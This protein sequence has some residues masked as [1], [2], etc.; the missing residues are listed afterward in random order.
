[1]SHGS[2]GTWNGLVVRFL[3]AS[4]LPGIALAQQTVR[5]TVRFVD[6]LGYSDIKEVMLAMG[7]AHCQVE[8]YPV[9]GQLDLLDGPG[10][11][12][13]AIAQFGSATNLANEKCSL[14]VAGSSISG[15][16]N[17]LSVA[18]AVTFP[19]IR[20]ARWPFAATA[21]AAD[22]TALTPI[23][24]W[25]DPSPA[26][27]S[28]SLLPAEMAQAS[29][30]CQYNFLDWPGY[31]ASGPSTTL[32][33]WTTNPGCQGS[34][35][36][37]ASW[38][39]LGTPGVAGIYNYIPVT[40]AQ[41]TNQYYLN[42]TITFT[43]TNFSQVF[44]VEQGTALDFVGNTVSFAPITGSGKS[45][46]FTIVG[47]P[48]G[49][50]Y[51]ILTVQFQGADNST[52]KV[53]LVPGNPPYATL[54]LDSGGQSGALN[55]PSI[56][57][58]QNDSC[59][60]DGASSTYSYANG[61][62]TAQLAMSFSQVF[63]GPRY[64]TVGAMTPNEQYQF[65]A[66][67]TWVVPLDPSIPGLK[68]ASSHS[69]NFTQ[70][71]SNNY[72]LNVA[73]L[74]GAAASSGTVTVTD[75]LPDQV[76]LV[77]MAGTGWNCSGATCTRSDSLAGGA[78]Y[79]PITVTV[80][81]G[82]SFLGGANVATVSGGGSGSFTNPDYTFY[83]GNSQ[84]L[85]VSST[86][87]GSFTQA[88]TNA[89]YTIVV[90][91]LA[92]AEP[93]AGSVTVTDN[94]PAGLT[95][96][97]I[98][99][100]GWNCTAN[101]VSCSRSDVLNPGASY[102]A[103]TVT[104]NVSPTA[105]S[106][107]VNSVSVNFVSATDS[108][109][110]LPHPPAIKIQ[111]NVA[112]APFSL[113]NGTVYQAPVTFYW[114]NGEQHTVTWLT[115]GTG[116]KYAFQ[117]WSDGGSN[118]RI[119]AATADAT[120]TA[121]LQA[122][123]LLTVNNPNPTYGTVTVSPTSTD[124]YYAAG[125]TVT[126][127]AGPASGMMTQMFS[128]NVTGWSPLTIN[129]NAPV[130]ETAG[131]SCV[132][133]VNGIPSSVYLGPGPASG[134]IYWGANPACS[135]MSVT[136]SVPWFSLGTPTVFAGYNIIPYSISE[137]TDTSTRNAAISVSGQ[138]YPSLVSQDGEPGYGISNV[139]SVSPSTGSGSSQLFTFQVFHPGGWAQI[140]SDL[141]FASWCSVHISGTGG[142]LTV[143]LYDD[144][145]GLIPLNLPGSGAVRNSACSI[146]TSS[147]SASA[148]GNLATIALSLSFTPAEA[149]VQFIMAYSTLGIWSV[150]A[151][152]SAA[153]FSLQETYAYFQGGINRGQTDVSLWTTVINAPG[154]APSSGTVSVTQSLPPGLSVASISGT[155]WDC[156]GT[157]CTRSDSL[158][159]GASYPAIDLAVNVAA[160]ATPGQ[161]IVLVTVSGGG[162]APFTGFDSVYVNSPPALVVQS[163]HPGNF[164]AGQTNAE[165][166]I[167]IY[168]QGN[169]QASSGTVTAT[170]NLPNGLTLVSMV[171]SG[172]NCTGNTCTRSDSLAGGS[173]YY[174]TIQVSV[175]VA[176]N[177][178]SPLVNQVSVSGG[179]SAPASASDST[180]IVT[181]PPVFGV[182]LT[183]N[184][185]FESGGSG[186]AYS[187]VISN[188]AGAPATSGTVSVTEN[189]PS[190]MTISSMSGQGWSCAGYQCTRTDSLAGG[191]SYPPITIG[192][193]VS[194]SSTSLTNQVSAA[195]SGAATVT[196][197]DTTTVVPVA[198]ISASITDSGNFIQ[199]EANAT[200]TL[201]IS[202]KPGV[203]PF[204]GGINFYAILDTSGLQ[205]VS[206]AGPGWTCGVNS[207]APSCSRTDSL[208]AGSS[209]PPVTLTV[210]V[211]ANATS[212]SA[213]GVYVSAIGWVDHSTVV[214]P[215]SAGVAIQAN[216]AGAPF[217]LEDGS[218]HLTPAVFYWPAG[219]Q[220][221][222]TWLNAIPGQ[223][224][225]RYA[226]QNWTDGGGNPRTFPSGMTGIY[227]AKL[228]AQYLLTLTASPASEGTVTA[229]PAS[230]D[231]FYAAGQ[232]VTAT[233]NPAPGFQVTAFTGTGYSQTTQTVVMNA[234]QSLTANFGCKFTFYGP[235]IGSSSPGP[236]SQLLLWTSGAGCT[237]TASTTATW[238][239]IGNTYQSN[240]FNAIPFS[241]A[242]N[243]GAEQ[244]AVVNASNQTQ[245]SFRQSA[246]GSTTP[247]PVSLAPK[248]GTGAGQ[249]FAVQAYDSAGYTN[250]GEVDVILT[251]ID[252]STCRAA[253]SSF[254][255]QGSL[256]LLGDSGTFMG[257]L[258]L[259][260]SGVLANSYCT[261]HAA[262]SSF[263]GSG[264]F[265]TANFDL[266]F[267]TN[268]S[269]SKYITGA[270]TDLSGTNGQSNVLGT[271]QVT[272]QPGGPTLSSPPNADGGVALAPSLA[273]ISA[274]GATSFDVYFG[275]PA[276]PP[277]VASTSSPN[278][279]PA[280]L[281]PGSTYYWQVVAKNS[282]GSNA[283][284]IWS[285]TTAQSCSATVR[286]ASPY[287]IAV[288]GGS[289]AVTI[290]AAQGCSWGYTSPV[291]W[292]TFQPSG[293]LS[294]GN[295]SLAFTVAASD[296]PAPRNATVTVAG[297]SLTI[298]QAGDSICDVSGDS[299]PTLADIQ[300][301]IN[302]ALGIVAPVHYLN[303]DNTIDVADI[304]I[305]SNAMLIQ[306]C[307]TRR[308]SDI[309]ILHVERVI[310]DEFAATLYVF[311]HQRGED[312]LA[313]GGV[314]Q[315]HL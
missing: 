17:Q 283:S 160:N 116:A 43:G 147:S 44:N 184:G 20:E 152:P 82:A 213:I 254:S 268:F 127:T 122:Q 45:Q 256:Y 312:D 133:Y 56:E 37:S 201:T 220:H 141:S 167:S 307:A 19:E 303:H 106:P 310:F 105:S 267:A 304:Q 270:A 231:G 109:V 101:T 202:N 178:T 77:S 24:N 63:A 5:F 286:A 203:M 238:L 11:I 96:V 50:G 225:A 297:Q 164:Y 52:C 27:E 84:Q 260:G 111:A 200:L 49:Y 188:R 40:V 258:N 41:N 242:E 285:F 305:V 288:S 99:G 197:N 221:T 60:V 146:D 236:L 113:D 4:L 248:Q 241:A 65:G 80:T 13:S 230:P 8:A 234:P 287:S 123:Y 148:S 192:V 118:P 144:M 299:L 223:T 61:F 219:G 91:D 2:R 112:G 259:P 306:H 14:S 18:V 276:T 67:G 124:G 46:I 103:I 23:S 189:P 198:S 76:T 215:S 180:V 175:N 135:L 88:Q 218:L 211:S 71:Q 251:G 16:G 275:T 87:S 314:F 110:I 115:T 68:I 154:A 42:G 313:L 7:T 39:T 126:L 222:V 10:K 73:N 26:K 132:N 130:T 59:S 292:V 34:A 29:S 224:N 70:D 53:S 78:S 119:F 247:G 172:W 273:W 179:G 281:N 229:N 261:L 187:V 262:S 282:T 158:A 290:T 92:G 30:N 6:P 86:H 181:N 195:A 94:L 271:W 257:P 228:A 89:M 131:F 266:T 114:A 95:L 199:G 32:L 190:G 140:S 139:V 293:G 121:T 177:A 142:A 162:S 117:S 128:G 277:Y 155:G 263:S 72:S 264:K 153:A 149:G 311:A 209:Y 289:P 54:A 31:L 51:L 62:F 253:M 204:T 85:S 15:R 143:S 169:S 100:S 64:I 205:F 295:G 183:D 120:Y 191:S 207:G 194:T 165:Y 208:P 244:D 3:L 249:I 296:S 239:T 206:I 265:V 269:G 90:S 156:T 216:V 102:P 246:A 58:L 237:L 255:G 302:E 12:R 182:S 9:T 217:T 79:P 272:S 75:A 210:N 104:V 243:T 173:A 291:P 280:T 284:A 161:D 107:L 97:S 174:G 163:S 226:F 33:L 168:N 308:A 47:Y 279:S 1:M 250:I 69:G 150:P 170:E 245:L 55:L 166:F 25:I 136:S 232:S 227:T 309:Q 301:E 125:T 35:V 137:N 28:A 83:N 22:G 151:S 159:A 240:G 145:G 193:S 108:T 66:Y 233:A 315:S 298:S 38:L 214:L 48:D 21:I 294:T 300:T 252:G 278:Y 93:T 81:V 134:I 98:A 274:S 157:T 185:P 36:S 57:N 138:N 212:P 171:G 235:P 176:A 196:A 186:S 129:V 74:A